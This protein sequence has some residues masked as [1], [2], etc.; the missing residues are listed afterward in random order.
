MKIMWNGYEYGFPPAFMP[1]FPYR[2][3]F[4]PTHGK[5]VTYYFFQIGAMGML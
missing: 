4:I 5:S 1:A 2:E 3:R